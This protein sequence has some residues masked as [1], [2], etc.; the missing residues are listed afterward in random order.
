[1]Q[2]IRNI[3]VVE[4]S[5]VVKFSKIKTNQLRFGKAKHTYW[6]VNIHKFLPH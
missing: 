6:K 2:E 4:N 5:N 3:G 1:V